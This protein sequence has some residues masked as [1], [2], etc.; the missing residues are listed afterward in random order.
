M[1]HGEARHRGPYLR[2]R[3]HL[4]GT[5]RTG[6][7]IETRTDGCER[8]E[9]WE[10]M[11]TDFFVVMEC[12]GIRGGGCSTLVH[13]LEDR[14]AC[15]GAQRP[16]LRQL[17]VQPPRLQ[18]HVLVGGPVPTGRLDTLWPVTPGLGHH[19]EAPDTLAGSQGPPARLQL[20]VDVSTCS[21]SQVG[22]DCP[23]VVLC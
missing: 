8:L 5:S 22:H 15:Q 7:P 2:V 19:P 1:L 18:H 23:T 11:G 12:S 21:G 9:G 13:V 10:F 3:F 4:R 6:K 14:A 17:H 20:R 16:G